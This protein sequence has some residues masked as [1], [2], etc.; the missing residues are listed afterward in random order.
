MEIGK[1]TFIFAGLGFSAGR[2]M[3]GEY[4]YIVIVLLLIVVIF[5]EDKEAVK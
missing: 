5:L 1:N 2:I 3:N 4:S